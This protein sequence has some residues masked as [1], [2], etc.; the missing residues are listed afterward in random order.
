[1]SLGPKFTPS[2]AVNFSALF[3]TAIEEYKNHTGLDHRGQPLFQDLEGCDSVDKVMAVLEK[4]AREF[5]EF[6]KARTFKW[7]RPMVNVLL[8]VNETLSEGVG[9]VSSLLAWVPSKQPL[10]DR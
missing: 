7:L 4:Q 5:D 2:G 9:L 6:R 3:L 10:I 8:A 1:M